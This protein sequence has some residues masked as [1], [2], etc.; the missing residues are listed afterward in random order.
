MNKIIFLDMDGV[1][2]GDE[3]FIPPGFNKQV[4]I[5][6]IGM[7]KVH[8]LRRIIEETGAKVVIS[9]CWRHSWSIDQFNAVF[10]VF[11]YWL[12]G[13]IIG[14]TPSL[15]YGVTRG[16]EINA[17][18]KTNNFTGKFVILDDDSDMEPYMDYLVQTNGEIGLTEADAEKAIRL[19][20]G[21]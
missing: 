4:S 12:D 1:L 21:E 3:D 19:L 17:W 16:Y 6:P 8:L 11:S 7:K 10:S 9:S 5:H 14:K 18:I 15:G 13:W 2:N 20:N